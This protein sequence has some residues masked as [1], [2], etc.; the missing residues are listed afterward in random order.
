MISFLYHK[1]KF[2][3][4]RCFNSVCMSYNGWWND[5]DFGIN[6]YV[7]CVW[8]VGFILSKFRYDFD[9]PTTYNQYPIVWEYEEWE[10]WQEDEHDFATATYG[11]V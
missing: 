9:S 1:S 8:S 5:N 11:F 6:N 4:M 2:D 3:T 10:A 7:M